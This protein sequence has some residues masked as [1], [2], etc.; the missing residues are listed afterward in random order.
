MALHLRVNNFSFWIAKHPNLPPQGSFDYPKGGYVC[1]SWK[2][3]F[4]SCEGSTWKLLV[5]HFLRDG[6]KLEEGVPEQ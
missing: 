4:L 3:T 2:D 5:G 6:R 1:G